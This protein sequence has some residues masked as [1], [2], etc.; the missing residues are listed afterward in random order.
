MLCSIAL[1]KGAVFIV[2]AIWSTDSVLCM[3]SVGSEVGVRQQTGSQQP[4]CM[5]RCTP[6]L[7]FCGDHLKMAGNWGGTRL[8]VYSKVTAHCYSNVPGLVLFCM[9]WF[10]RKPVVTGLC[11]FIFDHQGLVKRKFSS[12]SW[13]VAA[14]CISC[15]FCFVFCLCVFP[16]SP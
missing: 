5:Y 8:W 9:Y 15:L 7:R 13:S 16:A 11:Y 4:S 10:L 12:I 6:I 2:T 3:L 1:Q 14:P